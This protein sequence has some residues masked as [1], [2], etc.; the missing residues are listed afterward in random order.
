[1]RALLGLVLALALAAS[2]CGNGEKE[3]VLVFVAASLTDAMERLGRDFTEAEGTRVIFNVGGSGSLAQQIIRGAPADVFIS[4]GDQPMDV[5]QDRDMLAP[6]TR[7]VLLSNELILVTR[8][9]GTRL[10][11][12]DELATADV[13]VAVA[14]PELAPAGAYAREALR[15]MDLWDALGSRLILGQD[16]R[17][18]L[19][20]LKTGNIDA[21]IVYRTD[22]REGQGFDV[23]TSFPRA[24]TLPS[25]I[26]QRCC[27]AHHTRT[28]PWP[29]WDISPGRGDGR[30]FATSASFR[31]RGSEPAHRKLG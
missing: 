24:P 2:A 13:R 18:T 20:Y 16:V 8:E 5:L 1:M 29:S 31:W 7:S 25:C 30:F 3:E 23:V 19:G 28:L 22:V 26:R 21:A 9:G 12:V 6:G 14:D 17:V 4:A 11:S 10:G 15:S 27:P